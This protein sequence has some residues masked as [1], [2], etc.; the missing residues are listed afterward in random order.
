MARNKKHAA[1]ENHERWLVSYADFITLLFAFFVVMFASSQADKG[2][3]EQMS[4]AVR[5]ALEGKFMPQPVAAILGGSAADKGRGNNQMKGPAEP[6]IAEMKK[7]IEEA[8]LAPSYQVLTQ[9]LSEEI[10]AGQIQVS[11]QSR[12]LVISF[13]QAALFPS[14]N[15]E[16]SEHALAGLE[17]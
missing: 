12:G 16:V 4:E 8:E 3:A 5:S 13:A 2:K 10:A 14:G 1:H 17:K 15:D 7:H 11:L 6:S 9:D